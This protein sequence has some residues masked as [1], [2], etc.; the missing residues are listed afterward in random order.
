MQFEKKNFHH[1]ELQCMAVHTYTMIVLSTKIFEK[2]QRNQTNICTV[3]A[4]ES[5]LQIIFNIL[6]QS[7]SNIS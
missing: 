5:G 7:N 2:D 6:Y 3:C 1:Q 4:V